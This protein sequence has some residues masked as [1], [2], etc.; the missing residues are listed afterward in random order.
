MVKKTNVKNNKLITSPSP[1]ATGGGGYIFEQLVGTYYLISMLAMELPLGPSRGFIKYIK[2]QTKY[3]GDYVDDIK[4]I[5][6]DDEN[7]EYKLMLQVRHRVIFT[8]KN[9]KFKKIIIDCWSDYRKN[10]FNKQFDRV[11]IAIGVYTKNLDIHGQPLLHIADT[12]NNETDFKNKIEKLS[13]KGTRDFYILFK[14]ILSES[15]DLEIN[16]NE[17][18]KFLKCFVLLHFDLENNNSRDLLYSLNTAKNIVPD[19]KQETAEALFNHLYKIA[20]EYAKNAGTIDFEILKNDIPNYLLS[21]DQ[22][23]LVS[24]IREMVEKIFNHTKNQITRQKQD[25]KYIPEVFVE[26]DSIKEEARYFINPSL[27]WNKI[28]DQIKRLDFSYLNVYLNEIGYKSFKFILPIKLERAI[29][30]DEVSKKCEELL[31]FLNMKKKELT[32]LDYKN[33]E[34]KIPNDKF[35]LFNETKH[36]YGNMWSF[37]RKIDELINLVEILDHKI[38]FIVS[39]AGQGKTNFICDL[40]EKFIIKNSLLC[41]FFS[42][43]DFNNADLN[44]LGEEILK[45]ILGYYHKINFDEFI[46][47]MEKICYGKNI[48]F[49]IIIDGLNEHKN[50]N[51][52]SHKLEQFI[53]YLMRFD[54]VKIILTCRTEYFAERFN[55]FLKSNFA[56]KIVIRKNF[57]NFMNDIKKERMFDAYLKFFNIN[58]SFYSKVVYKKLTN[59]P[60]LLRIFCEANKNENITVIYDIYKENLFKKYLKVKTDEIIKREYAKSLDVRKDLNLKK[61]LGKIISYM[62][63]KKIFKNIPLDDVIDEKYEN[64]LIKII[65]EDIIFRRDL[66]KEDILSPSSNVLNFTFDEFRDYLIANH[67]ITNIFT[68]N[69]GEFN[70]TINQL[71][72]PDV[73][74]AEGLSKYIFYISKREKDS[75]L[76]SL[77]A[78]KVWYDDIYIDCIFEI[79]DKLISKDDVKKIKEKFMEDLKFSSIIILSLMHRYDLNIFKNLNIENLFDIIASLNSDEYLELVN[80]VFKCSESYNYSQ[81]MHPRWGIDKLVNELEEILFDKKD[82]IGLHSLFELLLLLSGVF[83]ENFP[84]YE[85]VEVYKKYMKKFSEKAKEQ[86]D[87]YVNIKNDLIIK[88]IKELFNY[89]DECLSKKIK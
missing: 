6:T 87:K 60:L 22:P 1:Y 28:I 8:E 78:Q 42:A 75:D 47:M 27:F 30:I 58:L 53:E 35:Y 24:N 41:V 71:I 48:F 68:I 3:E 54:F 38:F 12:S 63:D 62:L 34:N 40:I 15:K 11:G 55:N 83:Y 89:Y 2:F 65:D 73:P 84:Y 7:N 17:V 4:I 31:K 67:L 43:S 56:E 36:S 10:D 69:P 45:E 59:D 85:T 82:F 74:I 14:K 16:D 80:P 5:T 21:K 77:I 66:I 37:T 79:E 76:V 33:L 81:T 61:I 32:D 26:I 51:T 23:I 57:N 18:W 25:K 88:R 49:T 72:K 13:S 50:I 19:K 64:E 39:K 70:K 20:G 52:F 9:E 29:K 86:L 44:N 46:K